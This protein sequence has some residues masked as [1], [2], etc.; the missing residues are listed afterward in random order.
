MNKNVTL[1][2]NKNHFVLIRISTHHLFI[3][4]IETR[5]EKVPKKHLFIQILH[6]IPKDG[7]AILFYLF[8]FIKPIR[9]ISPTLVMTEI[10]KM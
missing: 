4:L 10:L 2:S 3:T 6:Y 7:L 8:Q 5:T 1:I 9:G